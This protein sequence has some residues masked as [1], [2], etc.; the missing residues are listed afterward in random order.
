MAS[1][2]QVTANRANAQLSTGPRS[3]E[4]K[5]AS[6]RNATKLGIYSEALI[7]P[8]ENPAELEA[9]AAEYEACYRPVGPIESALIEKAVRA[10]WM[11]RR[12]ARLEA[13]VLRIRAAEQK[14]SPD[15]MGAALIHDARNGNV[16]GRIHRKQQ[17]AHREWLIVID[18][19][20]K[21]SNHRLAEQAA[22]RTPKSPQPSQLSPDWLRSAQSPAAPPEPMKSSREHGENLA[23]RL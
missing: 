10:Q 16:L 23:L 14:D 7:I 8:G 11:E 19:F 9:L 5:T 12:Y 22:S 6:S 15:P 20:G 17:A 1:I 4:G 3:V 18:V 13:E 2:A 21:F